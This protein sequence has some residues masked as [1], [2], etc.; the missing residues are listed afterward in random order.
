MSVG[1]IWHS[2]K[3]KMGAPIARD[4]Q[5]VH[6]DTDQSTPPVWQALLF[7]AAWAGVWWLFATLMNVQ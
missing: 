7:W 4:A 3:E 2:V 5:Q 1:L 6:Y